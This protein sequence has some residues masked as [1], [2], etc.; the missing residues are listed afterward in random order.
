MDRQVCGYCCNAQPID[1]LVSNGWKSCNSLNVIPLSLDE[2]F[3][4]LIDC[5]WTLIC[6]CVG[7][8]LKTNAL[9][10]LLQLNEDC[11]VIIIFI[12]RDSYEDPR[13]KIRGYERQIIFWS[14]VFLVRYN[15]FCAIIPVDGEGNLNL[16]GFFQTLFN[17]IV[18]HVINHQMSSF[19]FTELGTGDWS[20]S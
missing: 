19:C 4:L 13:L 14:N 5:L 12:F 11:F 6:N 17:H 9:K 10:A 16:I 1:Q 3:L 7:P 18:W 2:V 15:L 20:S 8:L